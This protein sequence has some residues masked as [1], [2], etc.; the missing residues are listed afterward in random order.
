MERLDRDDLPALPLLDLTRA[1]AAVMPVHHLSEGQERALGYGQRIASG[2]GG[3]PVAG[4]GPGG[5][6]VA[7]LDESGEQARSHVVFPA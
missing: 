1:A 7:I 3:D 4:I 6:L 2:P 5:R